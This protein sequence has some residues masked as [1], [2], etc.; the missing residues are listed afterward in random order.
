[1]K[2]NLYIITNESLY[3]KN[4]SYYCDNIDLKSI[5][6]SLNEE[7]NVFIIGRRSK[8]P[9]SKK[10][11]IEN[12]SVSS[13]IIFYLYLLNLIEVQYQYSFF[14][15]FLRYHYCKSRKDDSLN[16]FFFL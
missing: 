3:Y 2:I 16:L 7:T 9:R 4:G 14:L 10:V 5:P 1:M 15:K 8:K 12:I 13:N 11:D 6:E